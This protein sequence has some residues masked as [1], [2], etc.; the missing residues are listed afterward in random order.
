VSNTTN[1]VRLAALILY[2]TVRIRGSEEIT[3]MCMSKSSV[4]IS[5][6][7]VLSCSISSCSDVVDEVMQLTKM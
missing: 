5:I 6:S 3:G 7:G 4:L 2:H 1:D